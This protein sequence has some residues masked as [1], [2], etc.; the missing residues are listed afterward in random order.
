M[1][2]VP[3]RGS[4][5]RGACLRRRAT[6]VRREALYTFVKRSWPPYINVQFV[7]SDR[8]RAVN[9]PHLRPILASLMLRA[10]D[11]HLSPGPG[12]DLVRRS[13]LSLPTGVH[14]ARYVCG[15]GGI[16]L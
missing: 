16:P 10:Y 14:P 6:P 11:P 13:Y 4:P 9:C 3:W 12:L 1:E 7:R 15:E 2:R 8:F 5:A